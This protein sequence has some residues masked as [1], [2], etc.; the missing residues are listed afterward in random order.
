[1]TIP[2][3][4]QDLIDYDNLYYNSGTPLV[5][6]AKY[7]SLK[8]LAKVKYPIHTYF[9]GIGA[10]VNLKNEKVKLPHILGSLNKIKTEEELNKWY[11]QDEVFVA[12][13]K[14]DG[15]SIYV[16]YDD[17][18]LIQATTRGNGTIGQDITEKAKLFCP[19]PKNNVG[20]LEVRGEVLLPGNKYE[21]FGMK[22]RRNGASGLLNQKGTENCE[23]LTTKFYEII[24]SSIISQNERDF[25]KERFKRLSLNFD[26]K[27]LPK[28][29][30][31]YPGSINIESIS[32]KLKKWKEDCKDIY[33]I[34]GIVITKA[35][36][37][38]ENEYY[39]KNKI[40]FKIDE[41]GIIAEVIG[42]DWQTSRTGKVKPVLLIKAVDLQGVTIKRVTAHNNKYIQ[43]NK[44]GFGSEIFII[45]SGDVIPYIT[46]VKIPKNP[47]PYCII[48]CPSCG[49][50]LT[51]IGVDL[52]CNNDDCFT[53]LIGKISYFFS[54]LDVEYFSEKTIQSLM[55]QLNLTSIDDFYNLTAEDMVG[56]KGFGDVKIKKIISEI[57]KSLNCKPENLLTAFGIDGIGKENSKN[58]F[59]KYSF[60]E[61]F[62]LKSIE[63]IDSF[64]Q[65]T[66][67]KFVEGIAK[68]RNLYNFLINKGLS[69]VSNQTES[70]LR[71]KIFSLTGT[72]NFSRKQYKTKIEK[73]GGSVGGISK[74][75]NLLVTNDINSTSGK[76]KKA[77]K[78]R[79]LIISY[80]DLEK[81]LDK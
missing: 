72:G 12:S 5:S 33:D 69:F 44:I 54:N 20:S 13:E 60:A 14:L 23:F 66:S 59:E 38:R 19:I 15:I 65:I 63:D 26:K 52:H 17:N 71:N 34:D 6:D 9:L 31:F 35:I 80:D 29:K 1:M 28:I 16:K 57:K 47:K 79:I 25:E 48:R 64:G 24:D 3:E 73:L 40:A 75:T 76:M 4:I 43:D 56:L 67:E 51:T 77:K 10:Q 50:K 32:K 74:S 62:K 46:E 7:D 41:N 36:S 58:L 22:N 81:M 45:R 49:Y 21:E 55:N 42:C 11:D 68:N 61:L 27:N 53:K 2:Q 18:K 78:M 8:D 37:R 39:P 30:I 70:L